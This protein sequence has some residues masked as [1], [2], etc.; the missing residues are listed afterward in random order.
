MRRFL[1]HL[2]SFCLLPGL[3]LLASEAVLRQSGEVWSLEQVFAYQQSHP[4]SLYLRATDQLFYAYKYRGVLEKQPSVLVAGS[5]RT[6]KFRAEMFGD[7]A[8][9]FYN[10]GGMVNSI[11]DAH[12]FCVSLPSSRTPRVLVLG[13]DLWWFNDQVTPVY[14]FAAEAAKDTGGFDEHVIALRW[15]LRHPRA[16]GGEAVSLIRRDDHQAVGIGARETGGGFRPDGSFKSHWPTPR[17]EDEW[18]FVD[19]ETPPVIDRVK[20]ASENFLPARGVSPG[21]VALLDA[22]LARLGQRHVLVIGYLPP[23][24]SDVVKHLRSDPRHSRLWSDF[25]RTIPAVFRAHGFPIVDAS[26]PLSL[27]M[28]DR[29]M[30]DGMHAEETFHVGVLKALLDDARVRA[31]LPGATSVVERALASRRTNYWEPDLG[32]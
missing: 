10:A 14:S 17:S 3:L 5:S 12:D 19:R 22:V 31:A 32:S 23:F 13:V 16:F 26:E 24:S 21:R 6:M 20:T 1:L 29:A 2:L 25:R 4:A 18:R 28:D 30:S 9:S 27:G 8:D 11:R 7:R 15:L